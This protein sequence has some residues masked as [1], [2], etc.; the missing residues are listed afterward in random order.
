MNIVITA[1]IGGASVVL[2][3]REAQPELCAAVGD[4]EEAREA[5]LNAKYALECA[6][7]KAV[8]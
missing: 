5:Y 8:S 1:R 6:I 3:S 2:D 7:R 4:H